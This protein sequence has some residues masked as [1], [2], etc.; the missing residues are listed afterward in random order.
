MTRFIIV[1]W[2]FVSRNVV[3]EGVKEL[4][5]LGWVGSSF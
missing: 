1:E 3:K 4:D 5:G 2:I